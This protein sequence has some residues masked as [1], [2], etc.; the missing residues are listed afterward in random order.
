MKRPINR[1]VHYV[2]DENVLQPGLN[3]SFRDGENATT[4]FID[5]KGKHE[6]LSLANSG[7]SLEIAI[8]LRESA[9]RPEKAHTLAT[10][11]HEL[12]HAE[13][14]L[15][16]RSVFGNWARK[17]K[18]RTFDPKTERQFIKW[19]DKQRRIPK[20]QKALINDGF[21]SRVTYNTEV[22]GH[23]EGF[24][25]AFHLV[26]D[27]HDKAQTDYIFLG[28][29]GARSTKI[30]DNWVKASPDVRA[31]ALGR[32]QEYYCNTLGPKHR[33]AFRGWLRAQRQ[34]ITMGQILHHEKSEADGKLDSNNN[35]AFDPASEPLRDD[36]WREMHRKTSR[37]NVLQQFYTNQQEGH[38]D[39][40]ASL[41]KVID[42]KC[43][44]F[45]LEGVVGLETTKERNRP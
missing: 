25:T 11:R 34:E 3:L 44:G 20:W 14:K 28:L 23:V 7:P 31:E 35:P 30:L 6:N 13:H 22:L 19:L 36:Q 45:A 40:I 39:F 2:K 33:Q 1:G 4:Y 24:M 38:T 10:L 26:D 42:N 8:V 29:L 18:S 43:K 41:D 37:E 32:L 16:A 21:T 12:M 17:K 27:P 5:A 15:Q 9:F